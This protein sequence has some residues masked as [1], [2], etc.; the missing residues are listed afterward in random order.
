MM[1][2][3]DIVEAGTSPPTDNASIMKIQDQSRGPAPQNS[4]LFSFFLV[5]LQISVQRAPTVAIWGEAPTPVDESAA[6]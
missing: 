5:D 4:V 3:P 1:E 2:K 6:R